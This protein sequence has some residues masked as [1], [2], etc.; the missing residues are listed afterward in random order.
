MRHLV[1]FDV[2]GTLTRTVEVDGRCY[3]QALGEELGAPVET[4]WSRYRSATDTGIAAEAFERRHGRRPRAEEM[5][6]L[7]RRFLRLLRSSGEAVREVPGAAALLRALRARPDVAVAVATGC[8][9]ASAHWKLRRAGIP[10]EGVPIATADDAPAREEILRTAMRRAGRFGRATYV[11]DR[12][13]DL[14]ASRAAGLAFVGIEC[15]GDGQP[16]RAAGASVLLPDFRDLPGFLA[17]LG[18][19]G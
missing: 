11:G 8:W 14:V 7:R 10:V 4:D 6:A 17:A 5:A 1:V 18:L 15:D 3:A 2:D 9:R 12:P 13:W 19:Q 16:L